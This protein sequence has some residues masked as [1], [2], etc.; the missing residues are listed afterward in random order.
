MGQGGFVK[1]N[2][3]CMRVLASMASRL[4]VFA[5]AGRGALGAACLHGCFATAVWSQS[6]GILPSPEVKLN[7]DQATV[8][9]GGTVRIDVLL[10]DIGLPGNSGTRLVG[11]PSCGTA[12]VA[13][14]L[15]SVTPDPDCS[16]S[17]IV[18]YGVVQSLTED[19]AVVT[20]TLEEPDTATEPERTPEPEPETDQTPD[21][22]AQDDTVNAVA[23]EPLLI[24]ILNNDTF[25]AGAPP[26]LEI[27][28]QPECGTASISDNR[29]L[30]ESK[31]TCIGTAT[32]R[33]KFDTGESADVQLVVSAPPTVCPEVAG[34][35]F[36]RIPE[37]RFELAELLAADGT[38]GE[39]ARQ[40]NLYSDL[41]EAGTVKDFCISLSQVP[42]ATLPTVS[43]P[44][45]TCRWIDL[46]DL[47]VGHDIA[48]ATELAPT[49]LMEQGWDAGLPKP[50]EMIL[51]MDF[52]QS[53]SDADHLRATLAI[54]ISLK[55]G[56]I[57]WL[58]ASCGSDQAVVIG[59][60]CSRVT[61][62]NCYGSEQ[63]RED[64]GLRLVA[65][66]K[67]ES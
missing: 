49:L 19:T 34:L 52:L 47:S 27:V 67:S 6:S 17:I 39:I 55:R 24:N 43:E 54:E 4:G 56:A 13:G 11:Q 33:Y 42:R 3:G 10:N 62:V 53:S 64:F 22:I 45:S 63:V 30:Y 58:D 26:I 37:R 41:P 5:L 2:A 38:I 50:I 60:N 8:S 25:D 9:P 40:L 59:G 35:Q 48:S 46:E 57:E 28:S 18:R 44:S 16:G 65:R 31:N 15:L 36:V 14:S 12:S 32:M 51:A 20:I 7:P 61:V 21:R 1:I 29:I 23:G 66:P